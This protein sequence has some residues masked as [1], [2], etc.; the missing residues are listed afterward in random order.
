MEFGN[1]LASIT[2]REVLAELEETMFTY[3]K[4][5]T[6]IDIDEREEKQI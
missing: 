1:N 2:G 4:G 5:Q 3:R 6:N